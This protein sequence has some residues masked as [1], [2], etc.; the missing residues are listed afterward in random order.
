MARST[1]DRLLYCAAGG[2]DPGCLSHQQVRDLTQA[3]HSVEVLRA[4]GQACLLWA[5]DGSARC[6]R[7]QLGLSAKCQVVPAAD[8]VNA[9]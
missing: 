3:C 5:F 6:R 8:A 1:L 2:I 4:A 7:Q 9:P